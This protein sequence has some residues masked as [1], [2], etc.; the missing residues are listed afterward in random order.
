[1]ASLRVS[2]F[3]VTEADNK[4]TTIS[5]PITLTGPLPNAV[6]FTITTVAGTA[7]AG[8]DFQ[9][10]TQTLT[11]AAGSTQVVFQ[12]VI[13][14]DKT[15]ESI[16]T[17]TVTVSNVTGAPVTKPSGT[18]TIVDNDGALTASAEAPA[19]STVESLAPQQLDAAVAEAKA[20]WLTMRPDADFSGVTFSIGDLPEQQLGFALDRR[21]VID[22]T[23]AGWGWS[24]IDLVSV[25]LHELGHA[26]GLEHDTGG[27]MA[28]TLA[29]GELLEDALAATMISGHGF[30]QWTLRPL[31]QSP[32]IRGASRPLHRAAVRGIRL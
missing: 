28:E 11:I 20:R 19:G 25:L 3:T 1:V 4:T 24:R 23:A 7:T 2:D 10:K 6:T 14:N 9:A 12:V 30:G 13:V 21:I 27:L 31:L 22:A 15:A 8:S 18:V 17:F 29:P 26:L 32:K 5:I 16:E